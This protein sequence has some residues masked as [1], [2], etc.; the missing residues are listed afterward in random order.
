[1]DAKTFDERL[2]AKQLLTIERCQECDDETG[3]AGRADDS[4]QKPNC[5]CAR[6]RN[7][8]EPLDSR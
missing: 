6:S 2:A 5:S 1:M 3:R 8:P 7:W 4:L